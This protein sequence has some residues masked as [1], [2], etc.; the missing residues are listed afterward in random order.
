MQQLF[1]RIARRYVAFLSRT[2]WL[3][4]PLVLALAVWAAGPTVALFKHINTDLAALLPD[5]FPS[6]VT[7][8]KLGEKVEKRQGLTVVLEFDEPEVGTEYLPEVSAALLQSP[9]VNEALYYRDGFDFFKKNALLFLDVEKLEELDERIDREIQKRKLGGLYIDFEE[10]DDGGA[11]DEEFDLDSF[12]EKHGGEASDFPSKYYE[13]ESKKLYSILLH[14]PETSPDFGYMQ[15]T[16]D[17]VRARVEALPVVQEGVATPYYAGGF[18]TKLNEY[19]TLTRDLRMA[20][21][22][23]LI[24]ITFFLTWRFRRPDALLFVFVPFA[25]ALFWD[26]AI[27]ARVIGEL[28]IVTAFLFSILFGMGVDFGIHLL[29]RYWEERTSGRGVEEAIAATLATTGRSCLTAGFTTAPAFYLLMINDFKGFSEFGFIAGTGLVLSVAS[30][31][32]VL[33]CL[34]LLAE[35]I[36]LRPPKALAEPVVRL[37]NVGWRHTRVTVLVFAV[38]LVATVAVCIPRLRFEYDFKK[39][40]ARMETA[41]IAKD[42]MRESVRG[43]GTAAVILVEDPADIPKLREQ[44]EAII[45]REGSISDQFI[46][47]D[48]FVPEDQEEKKVIIARIDER[49]DDDA[50]KL[51]KE[52]EEQKIDEFRSML[53]PE[54]VTEKDLPDSVRESFFGKEEV[55]GQLVFIKPKKGIELDDG[56]NAMQ[57]ADEVRAFEV[58]GKRYDATSVNLIFADVLTTMLRDSKRAVPLTLFAVLFVLWLDFRRFRRVGIVASPLFVGVTLMF[59]TMCCVGI[60]LSFYN[61]VVL[62][63]VLGLGVD[64]GVH[65]YHRYL[66]GGAGSIPEA[67]RH[68]GSAIFVT[69]TTTMLGF[70]GL[71]FAN[72]AGLASLGTLAVIGITTCLVAAIIF[73]P[74]FLRFLEL[75]RR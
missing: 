41:D 73:F 33:P 36:G 23:A 69:A 7:A 58:D 74:A 49:L 6:V 48:R 21:I 24:G 31:W 43:G 16:L 61:M 75:R 4:L 57:F 19:H 3:I 51:L 29:A 42:K 56:R 14:S 63:V 22:V 28:N 52:N 10:E 54:T 67:M 32:L 47:Y 64:Y 39:L 53:H 34:F 55:P 25:C 27:T 11:D 9:Y 2:W 35:R 15:R 44:A 12:R 45:E 13:S 20:G 46:S 70:A 72:H 59:G 17:D 71:A 60:K 26:F 38:L 50:L 65:F 8:N 37:F 66:E 1:E 18:V 62:P 30:F 40:K 68:T 5:D